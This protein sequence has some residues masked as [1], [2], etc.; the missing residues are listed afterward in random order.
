MARRCSV[1]V[2]PKRSAIDKAI[3]EGSP[4]RTV[5][6]HFGLSRSAVE[7]HAHAHLP[8]L[9]TQAH[10]AV[11]AS[12][13]DDLLA[14]VGS[15]R[16]RALGLLSE[17]EGARD[18]RGAVAACR[19]VRECISLLAELAGRLDKSPKVNVLVMPEWVGLRATI[20]QALEPYPEA[21][22]CLARQLEAVTIDARH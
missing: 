3:V 21:R 19:E 8:A 11:I 2:H 22:L 5:A 20:L 10:E 18:V 13:A 12:D 1:C 9:L 4:Y 6:G 16:E 15:L 14:Q 17:A 7:R